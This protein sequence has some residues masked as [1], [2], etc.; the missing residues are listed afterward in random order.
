M[1]FTSFK[2]VSA[3]ALLL[4]ITACGGGGGGITVLDSNP[5]STG[6]TITG[7]AATGLAIADVTVSCKCAV[8]TGTATTGY[9]GKYRLEV[10]DGLAPCLLQVTNPTDGT[11]LHTMT[12]SPGNPVVANITPLTEMTTARVLRSK[13]EVF[14]AAFH[15]ATATEKV[16]P[17]NVAAAQT[18]VR[19]AFEGTLDTTAVADFITTPLHAAPQNNPDIGDVQDKLLDTLRLKLTVAELGMVGTALAGNQ[20]ADAIRQI[21]KDLI[22]APT[23]LPVAN[24][25]A[26]QTVNAG[27][28][29]TLDAR[30]SSAAAGRLLIYTWALS[31][32]PRDSVAVLSSATAAKPTFTADL[33]GTYI[34]SLKVHDGKV[35][36]AEVTVEVTA[37]AVAP[38]VST[39]AG[40]GTPGFAD[41]IATEASF[42]NPR[43][44]AVDSSGNVFVADAGN[45]AIRKITPAGVVSNFPGNGSGNFLTPYGVA[46]DS[47]DNVFV[48]DLG[49]NAIRKITPAGVV[50]TF[51]S[52]AAGFNGPMGVAVDSSGNV[53]VADSANHAIRKISSAGVVSI[54]AGAASSGFADGTGTA[55]SFKIPTGVAV[56]SL[57]NVYVADL[58]NNAIRKITT[59][60][61]VSTFAGSGSGFNG[62]TGVAV[63]SSGNVYV[64]DLGNQAIRKI[65]P[66]GVVSTWAGGGTNGGASGF[67]DGSGT[68]ARF[69]RPFGVAVESSGTV[70]VAD[71]DN[72]AIRKITP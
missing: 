5:S 34:A 41:G 29:V 10:K 24:A 11:K 2:P 45:N 6:L 52:S 23:T 31:T 27:A 35:S 66:A 49:N 58:G 46:I 12:A 4:A 25:G 71:T 1:N 13:P 59:T 51:A 63:D 36:S 61:I 3:L 9:S 70:Y 72:H 19:H 16:T 30:S 65:T 22:A 69:L 33:A 28:T 20:T 21:V 17:G 42:K 37:V 60:G 32:K 18:E 7:T 44:V 53:F 14:F 55:A 43:G 47:Q 68:Q 38:L 50:S 40:T 26:A 15:A 64:A 62:P 39:F 57:N 48:A 56:D 8:G 54:F 67:A